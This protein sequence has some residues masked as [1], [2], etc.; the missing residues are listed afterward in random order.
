MEGQGTCEPPPLVD[1]ESS[2]AILNPLEETLSLTPVLK[3]CVDCFKFFE[4][5]DII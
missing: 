2:G 4:L 3:R 5:T 1:S